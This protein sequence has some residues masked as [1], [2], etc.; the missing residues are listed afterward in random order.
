[1]SVEMRF[2][3]HRGSLADSM[4][5]ERTI[6][7]DYT[8]HKQIEAAVRGG[9]CGG[10]PDLELMKRTHVE[11]YAAGPDDRIGWARTYIITVDGYGVVGFCDRPSTDLPMWDD[12]QPPAGT[13]RE[14]G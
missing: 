3:L 1:M 6:S 11:P 9:P 5:T 10:L 12:P 14:E 4:A 2:R 7:S 8:F 13:G